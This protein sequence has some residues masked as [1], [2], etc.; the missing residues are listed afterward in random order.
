M[1]Y[2]HHRI[3]SIITTVLAIVSFANTSCAAP[4]S[5]TVTVKT[6]SG[7]PL[8]QVP[9][10]AAS[11]TDGGLQ[12]T[13]T[14]GATTFSIE[15]E[16]G[17]SDI[18]VRLWNGKYHNELSD[19]DKI[20][21]DAQYTLLREQYHFMPSYVL[22]T[23][24]GQTLYQYEITASPSVHIS[25]RFVD[26]DSQPILD[27]F[28]Q[29]TIQGGLYF[30]TFFDG[31][32]TF[33]MK[34]VKKGAAVSLF[35]KREGPQIYVL[36]LTASQ[37]QNNIVLGDIIVS[38]AQRDVPLDMT[39]INGA[40]LRDEHDVR[41]WTAVTLIRSDAQVVL[42]FTIQAPNGNVIER[43]PTGLSLPSTTT[44]IY[45]IVPGSPLGGPAIKLL[46]I[47]RAGQIGR[48]DLAGVPAINA[49]AG[50]TTQFTL[51]A[52]QARDAIL[53]AAGRVP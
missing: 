4:V 7:S 37:T 23:V 41:L 28:F 43:L 49:V 50:Q 18:I 53:Q 8:S 19:N 26:A 25:G 45:Y 44:G 16:P 46:D 20:L 34:G 30:D 38:P 31:N 13:D 17:N 51:D 33:T 5:V 35:L 42:S 9:V 27:P 52:A 47:L 40:D 12:F 29:L 48:L 14:T 36:P 3:V 6:D 2:Q 1:S 21:A 39:V 24:P 10:E 11:D 32:G 15:I 22:P